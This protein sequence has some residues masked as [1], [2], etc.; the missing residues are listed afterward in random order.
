VI[1]WSVADAR[2]GL[3]KGILAIEPSGP[4]IRE[5]IAKGAPDYFE[6]GVAAR[7]WGVTRGKIAYDPPAGH[8]TSSSSSA[9]TRPMVTG[10]CAAFC[11]PRRRGKCHAC[12]E[13][14]SSF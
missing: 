2:P 6:D 13:F 14:Q 12:A 1:G 11:R 8:R 3:V 5:T 4:P 10:W 7:P 9:R